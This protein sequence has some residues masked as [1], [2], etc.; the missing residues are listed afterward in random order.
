MYSFSCQIGQREAYLPATTDLMQLCKLRV[1]MY[2][3]PFRPVKSFLLVC[4][5][6]FWARFFCCLVHFGV[7]AILDTFLLCREV[8]LIKWSYQVSIPFITPNEFSSLDLI[9][10]NTKI[11][12]ELQSRRSRPWLLILIRGDLARS[13]LLIL[14][15]V[16]LFNRGQHLSINFLTLFL[17]EV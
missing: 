11:E 3:F 12:R 9:S 8:T 17:Y 6:F 1:Q 7:F 4:A 2:V 14:T 13:W 5:G 10:L 15:R 16:T